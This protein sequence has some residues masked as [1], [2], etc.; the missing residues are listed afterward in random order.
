MKITK[1]QLKKLIKEELD[2][3]RQGLEA[4]AA[5]T[6]PAYFVEVSSLRG[7]K[8]VYASGNE[9]DARDYYDKMV[10]EYRGNAAQTPS[11]KIIAGAG[12]PET[13]THALDQKELESG[14]KN[15]GPGDEYE[16]RSKYA[17]LP[18]AE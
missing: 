8:I 7:S 2:T 17:H 15:F 6:S 16:M 9:Q 13:I 18:Q 10:D 5:T 11:L 14:I 1:A 4:S 12:T 3:Q